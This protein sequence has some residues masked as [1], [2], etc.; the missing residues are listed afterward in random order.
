MALPISHSMGA[1]VP[2][3]G[4]ERCHWSGGAQLYRGVLQPVTLPGSRAERTAGSCAS[5]GEGATKSVDFE[6]DG[7]GQGSNS[8]Q[9]VYKISVSSEKAVLG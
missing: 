9:I 5:V 6:A 7:S 3:S 8:P 1:E 4:V 2:I